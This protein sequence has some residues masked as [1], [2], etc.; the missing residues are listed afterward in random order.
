MRPVTDR[1]APRALTSCSSDFITLSP[2]L[3]HH[4]RGPQKHL[5]LL[6]PRKPLTTL[7]LSRE[8][9]ALDLRGERREGRVSQASR[10]RCPS[11]T[12]ISFATWLPPGEGGGLCTCFLVTA[13]GFTQQRTIISEVSLCKSTIANRRPA[14]TLMLTD[15]EIKGWLFV[16]SAL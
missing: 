4:Q 14:L 13:G 3:H 16:P 7:K 5:R 2:D 6:F 11:S 8:Q 9:L 10:S 12:P 1:I 15:R